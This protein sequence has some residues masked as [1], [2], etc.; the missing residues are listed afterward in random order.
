MGTVELINVDFNYFNLSCQNATTGETET[1]KVFVKKNGGTKY[2]D[3]S[4]TTYS[5]LGKMK[6]GS[7]VIVTG[8]P[9]LDGTYTASAVVITVPVA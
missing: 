9:Q 2:I 4:D 5:S 3:S 8:T 7:Y 1:I 6:E